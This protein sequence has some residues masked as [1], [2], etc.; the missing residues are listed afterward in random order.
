MNQNNYYRFGLLV[1]APT[2]PLN[3]IASDFNVLFVG[4]AVL[5]IAVALI[6]LCI[7]GSSAARTK[8]R[9]EVAGYSFG[10]IFLSAIGLAIVSEESAHMGSTDF[11]GLIAF[12]AIPGSLAF[13]LPLVLSKPYSGDS[14]QK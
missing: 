7:K 6:F 2:F 11:Y 3:A 12:I 1:F 10:S 4:T 13:I 8:P 9:N 5:S 14:D